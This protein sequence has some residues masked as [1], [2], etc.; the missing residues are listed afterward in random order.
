MNRSLRELSIDMII[1]RDTLK[2]IQIKHFPCFTFK[3]KTRVS[4]YCAPLPL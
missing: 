4:F 2:N 1:Q 3:P